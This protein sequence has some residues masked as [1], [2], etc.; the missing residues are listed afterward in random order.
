MNQL[1]QLNTQAIPK[2]RQLS[3][4]LLLAKGSQL[5]HLCYPHH[6]HLLTAE[7]NGNRVQQ[8]PATATKTKATSTAQTARTAS[9][10]LSL[11]LAQ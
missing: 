2:A 8:Q 4:D 5:P 7:C 9:A 3:I 6:H 1:Y 10:A 11:L